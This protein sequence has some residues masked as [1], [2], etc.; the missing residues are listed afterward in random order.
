M[1]VVGACVVSG[2]TVVA[3][4]VVT[5]GCVV[6]ASACLVTNTIIQN[7]DMNVTF[8]NFLPVL[9]YGCNLAAIVKQNLFGHLR[10]LNGRISLALYAICHHNNCRPTRHPLVH[11]VP[12]AFTYSPNYSQTRTHSIEREFTDTIT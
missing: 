12:P 5:G 10:I 8:N 4:C 1:V 11:I 2:A 3:G 6:V 9:L 7:A